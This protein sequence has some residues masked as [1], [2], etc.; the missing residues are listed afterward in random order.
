MNIIILDVLCEGQ[1][2]ELFVKSVLNPFFMSLGLIV[3]TRLLVTSRRRN[4]K[5]GIISY[6]QAQGDLNKWIKEVYSKKNETHYFTTMF[7]WYA[8]P[9]DFPGYDDASMI[10]DPYMQVEK[11]E[12]EF[13]NDMCNPRFIPYIQLHEFEALL[14]CDISKLNKDYP[15]SRKEIV[16]LTKVITTYKGNPELIN[17]SKET[18]PS[19]RIINALKEK[20]HYNKPRSGTSVT[21]AIGL[22]ELRGKCS[23]FDSWLRK[24][25]KIVE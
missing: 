19:K 25:E 9:N 5:G 11:I 24:I 22:N 12:S 10:Q 7:D 2:E 16:E 14:F 20:Y 17:S 18:A 6:Q 4:A 3:K 8:L 13:S 23:H 1:T 15:N 21:T